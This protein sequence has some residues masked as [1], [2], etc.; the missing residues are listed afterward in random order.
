MN[1]EHTSPSEHVRGARLA[2]TRTRA[3]SLLTSWGTMRLQAFLDE[4]PSDWRAPWR[5]EWYDGIV[6]PTS[7][8][9]E[10]KYE[11]EDTSDSSYACDGVHEYVITG[12]LTSG[13]EVWMTLDAN[14][15]SMIDIIAEMV[16]LALPGD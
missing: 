5:N 12:S 10:L 2:A 13:T 8:S 15:T 7:V 11:R 14:E 4:P 1:A 3:E 6:D 16:A 9:V